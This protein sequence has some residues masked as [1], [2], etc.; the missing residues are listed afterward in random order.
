MNFFDRQV[1]RHL[2]VGSGKAD[3]VIWPRL[4][5][6]PFHTSMQ[7]SVA[8]LGNRFEYVAIDRLMLTQIR[9]DLNEIS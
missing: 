3:S 2:G 6:K 4:F 9:I 7:T 5:K 1:A 8:E